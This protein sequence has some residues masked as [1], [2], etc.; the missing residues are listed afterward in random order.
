[1]AD[2]VRHKGG[3]VEVKIYENEGHE[4]TRR[5][6]EIDAHSRAAKFLHKHVQMKETA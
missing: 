4:L 3:L 1:M 6:N 2:A 5:E